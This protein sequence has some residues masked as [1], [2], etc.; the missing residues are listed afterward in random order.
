MTR[1]RCSGHILRPIGRLAAFLSRRRSIKSR[2]EER[3]RFPFAAN[4]ND[5]NDEDGVSRPMAKVVD[6]RRRGERSQAVIS[7][8]GVLWRKVVVEHRVDKG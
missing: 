6:T 1:S 3:I 4:D 7:A 8:V 5:D 2:E